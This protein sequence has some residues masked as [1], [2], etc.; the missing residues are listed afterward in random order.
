MV[1][2]SGTIY[3]CFSDDRPG[4]VARRRRSKR[5]REVCIT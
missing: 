4:D 2:D 1:G 3:L 5:E